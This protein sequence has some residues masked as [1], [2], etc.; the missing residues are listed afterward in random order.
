MPQRRVDGSKERQQVGA[1][2]QDL[3]WGEW[4]AGHGLAV[5][6]PP[7]FQHAP[8]PSPLVLIGIAGIFGLAGLTV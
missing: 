1:K 4:R 3:F 6:S 8:Q 7:V 5:S 2:W